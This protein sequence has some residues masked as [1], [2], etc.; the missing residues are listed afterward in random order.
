MMDAVTLE[1]TDKRR[2]LLEVAESLFAQHGFEAV[3]VRHLAAEARINVA[4]VKYYFGSK[5]KLFEALIADK[6]PR[7]REQLDDLA[8]TPLSPWEKL[9]RSVDMYAEKF[10]RGRNFHKVVMREMSLCQRPEH[11]KTINEQM[12]HNLDVVRGFILE[13]QE[14]GIF[15]TVDVELTLATVFGALSA[16]IS[17][18]GLMCLML[19]AEAEDD[20]YTEAVQVR[21]ADHL[22]ALL[23]THL[24]I[25]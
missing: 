2:Q 25:E 4:M 22:K 16:F 1:K 20:V 3:S 9:A 23:R 10:F 5:D 14:K 7:T 19:Q 11:L 24:L 17:H 18:G 12:A 6:F 15:R 21:L 8:R 13:G